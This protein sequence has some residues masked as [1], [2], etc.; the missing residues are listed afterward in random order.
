[1]KTIIAI[2]LFVAAAFVN[3]ADQ[4]AAEPPEPAKVTIKGE[5]LEVIDAA[6]FTYLRL[7][8][9]DGEAWAS[10]PKAPFKKGAQATIDNAIAMNNFTSKSLNRT[11]PLI[12]LGG[13]SGATAASPHGGGDTSNPHAG[14][15]AKP[16]DTSNIRVAKAKGANA[17]TV[18]EIVT[19]GAAL[20]D[21]PVL[22][23]G[24][25]VKYN[26][27]IMGK[28]WLHLRDGSGSAKDESNDILVTTLGRAKP[29]DVVTVK[30]VIHT[31]KD[32]GSGYS[33][34]VLVEEATLQK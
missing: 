17:M 13:M 6:S 23:R 22:V 11:F 4:P 25:I 7:K 33:Y 8:T 18:A 28:N 3:A 29:G 12:Y 21:K 26:E 24:K 20:K 15:A 16:I 27:G 30:G 10:V 31:D 14:G 34:K 2:C 1:M 9:K 5:V 19:K 32:F